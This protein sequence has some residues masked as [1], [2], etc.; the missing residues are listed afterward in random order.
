MSAVGDC[1]AVCGSSQGPC[2][3]F[4]P[5]S[6]AVCPNCGSDHVVLLARSLGTTHREHR[7]DER[8]PAPLQTASTVRDPPDHGDCSSRA[9]GALSETPVSQEHH[10]WSLSPRE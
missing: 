2:S 1:G 7:Q 3:S 4:L 5:E 10:S 8:S 6:P 9:D